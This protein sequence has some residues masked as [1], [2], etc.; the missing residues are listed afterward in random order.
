MDPLQFI[1][2]RNNISLSQIA[3][4][5][6]NQLSNQKTELVNLRNHHALIDNE[7]SL[8]YDV[9]AW[10]SKRRR[11]RQE[12]TEIEK[13]NSL[14]DLQ[15]PEVAPVQHN[16]DQPI[17]SQM[18]FISNILTDTD[19][20]N[21]YGIDD[22]KL[23]ENYDAIDERNDEIFFDGKEEE[24]DE[25]PQCIEGQQ[26]L[27]LDEKNLMNENR[28]FSPSKLE[29]G[30]S[31]GFNSG[32]S[33]GAIFHD[34]KSSSPELSDVSST[35]EISHEEIILK[36][37]TKLD[38]FNLM[39]R[40]DSLT[41]HV[42]VCEVDDL[43]RNCG[44]REKDIIIYLNGVFLQVL[45]DSEI[46]SLIRESDSMNLIVYRG[47]DDQFHSYL[48]THFPEDYNKLNE[49]KNLLTS[50]NQFFS[51]KIE[52]E[53]K[54][55]QKAN[56][57]DDIQFK[58][59]YEQRKSEREKEKKK[60][61]EEIQMLNEINS[62]L[63]K[64]S[65]SFN[66]V[67]EQSENNQKN[68]EIVT[69]NNHNNN[70]NNNQNNNNNNKNNI[71]EEIY[72]D[73]KEKMNDD[74]GYGL[75]DDYGKYK[76]RI[77]LRRNRTDDTINNWKEE[78]NRNLNVLI[79]SIKPKN[80]YGDGI[81]RKKETSEKIRNS[82]STSSISTN[83][84]SSNQRVRSEIHIPINFSANEMHEKNDENKLKIQKDSLKKKNET[85]NYKEESERIFNEIIQT[86]DKHQYYDE[87]I[88]VTQSTNTLDNIN[89]T[90]T[91]SNQSVL[92]PFMKDDHKHIINNNNIINKLNEMDKTMTSFT[93]VTSTTFH[94]NATV[95]SNTFHDNVTV[96]STIHSD[97]STTLN[98]KKKKK[99]ITI[100]YTKQTPPIPPERKFFSDINE[101]STQQTSPL[102]TTNNSYSPTASMI[103]DIS[104]S[105][106]NP[107][108]DNRVFYLSKSVMNA[109][110]PNNTINRQIRKQQ[111]VSKPPPLFKKRVSISE[112]SKNYERVFPDNLPK[113]SS[114]KKRIDK[115]PTA[116]IRPHQCPAC[117][118]SLETNVTV[119][120]VSSLNMF[121]H[122][123]CFVCYICRRCLATNDKN[124]VEVNISG[125]RLFCNECYRQR[126]EQRHIK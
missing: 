50:L 106:N 3:N 51:E 81:G 116:N 61:N 32:Q 101:Q 43:L 4:E 89:Y 82:Y 5:Q 76:T 29:D 39:I 35:K 28:K 92:L 9:E 72:E 36:R 73:N 10:K 102:P 66:D 58:K 2:W 110:S 60:I 26:P 117:R 111:R 22:D 30:H 87:S 65:V 38:Q 57:M 52:K 75:Y 96:P 42:R 47:N 55:M 83:Q 45:D 86:N 68:N 31:S 84:L 56:Y 98:K 7:V 53:T 115:R 80:G 120:M 93:P 126:K 108:N 104:W 37:K 113:K 15:L 69:N 48:S 27:T 46:R 34:E 107:Y 54:K 85:M 88:D 112:I 122:E 1:R 49:K 8:D 100:E 13:K 119:M 97:D 59:F 123:N 11:N 74:D 21:V 125:D 16:D 114:L 6:L 63:I 40:R 91:L 17:T 78:K 19:I 14:P 70:K 25:E 121:F 33:S 118:Q 77:V 41:S 99:R 79:D 105:S 109:D 24:F 18:E 44:I 94:D 64:P 124:G 103:S 12:R 95:T 71:K 90:T 62:N 20:P 23:E 67:I